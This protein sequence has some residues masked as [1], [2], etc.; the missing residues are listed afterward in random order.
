MNGARA[1]PCRYELSLRPPLDQIARRDNLTRGSDWCSS[2]SAP[3]AKW[4]APVGLVS[5][6]PKGAVSR[7]RLIHFGRGRVVPA[8]TKVAQRSISPRS[9][10]MLGC[11]S[12]PTRFSVGRTGR[13]YSGHLPRPAS[14]GGR[15]RE[16]AR[17]DAGRAPSPRGRRTVQALEPPARP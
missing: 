5:Y 14:M 8:G 9:W 2:D 13:L 15:M 17:S 3:P 7:E 1:P 6:G 12:P 11:L 4:S 16:G 10:R